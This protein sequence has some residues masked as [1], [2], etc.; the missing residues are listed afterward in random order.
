[1]TPA[2]ALKKLRPLCMALPEA[3][4]TVTWDHP[5]WL[6]GKRAFVV[7]EPYKGE[8]AIAFK[9]TVADQ[10]ALTMDPRF[11]VTPYAGKYGWTSLRLTE[12]V[13]WQEVR[14]L[15]ES[16][17]RL[18]APK[19]LLAQLDASSAPREPAPPAARAQRLSRKPTAKRRPRTS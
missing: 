17:Y 7:L 10:T 16:A 4:E 14:A 1:M 2:A 19:R 12:R 9:A 13:D 11:Y 6:A 3:V 8:Y 5:T 15:V 18:A